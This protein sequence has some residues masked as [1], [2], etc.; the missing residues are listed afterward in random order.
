M[1]CAAEGGVL[2][3]AMRR[4][5]QLELVPTHL[6]EFVWSEWAEPGEVE[7][8]PAFERWKAARRVW[9]GRHPDSALGNYLQ[10]MK[11]ERLVWADQLGMSA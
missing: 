8:W 11:V 5:P 1:A 9:V 6:M 4:R 10:L 3:L 7:W 2:R